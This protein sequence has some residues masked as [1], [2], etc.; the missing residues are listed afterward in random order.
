MKN[1]ERAILVV[2]GVITCLYSL[3]LFFL[4]L[5]TIQF[6]YEAPSLKLSTTVLFLWGLFFLVYPIWQLRQNKP[7]KWSEY[8]L[9]LMAFSPIILLILYLVIYYLF[10][11]G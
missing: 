11:W 10:S 7:T 6:M 8:L 4:S 9:V 3:P 5:V 2:A 1:I